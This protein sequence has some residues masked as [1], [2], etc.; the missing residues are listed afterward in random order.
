MIPGV[1]LTCYLNGNWCHSFANPMIPGVT[2][3][4]LL[5]HLGVSAGSCR[6]LTGHSHYTVLAKCSSDARYLRRLEDDALLLPGF[7]ERLR[8]HM[9][10]LPPDCDLLSLYPSEKWCNRWTSKVWPVG[11][12]VYRA[13]QKTAAVVYSKKDARALVGAAPMDEGLDLWYRRLIHRGRLKAYVSCAGLTTVAKLS[14]VRDVGDATGDS[15]DL[16]GH[17]R[18]LQP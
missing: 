18:V 15:N 17:D 5:R 8:S 6:S 7:E 4:S 11:G 10:W 13:Y 14:S 9:A 3:V 2:H 12:G 16:L 1:S